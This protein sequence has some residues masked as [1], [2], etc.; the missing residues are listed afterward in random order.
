MLTFVGRL[1]F[2]DIAVAGLLVVCATTDL[3][4][5]RIYNVVTYPA[6]ILGLA[7]AAS[8]YGPDVASAA[9]GC[10][11]GGLPL[12]MLFALRWMGGGDVKLMAAVGALKGFPFIL[13]A[14]F[15]SIF[16]GGVCAALVLIWRGEKRAIAGDLAVVVRWTTGRPGAGIESIPPRGGSFPF[17]VAICLGTLIAL[18]LEWR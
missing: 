12:Y 18:A 6:I 4:V 1:T 3:R 14:M 15:Y 13:D 17:G 9:L 11:V 2:V 16:I 7:I 8:G 10:L 5:G